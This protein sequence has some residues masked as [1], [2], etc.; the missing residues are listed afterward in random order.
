M[1]GSFTRTGAA[2]GSCLIW[3]PQV[4]GNGKDIS[5]LAFTNQVAPMLLLTLLLLKP[6]A[7]VLCMRSGAPGGLFTP[8]LTAGV[9]LGAVPGTFGL[10]SGPVFP[11]DCSRYLELELFWRQPHKAQS[12]QWF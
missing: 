5:Q 11:L 2:R 9:L 1:G 10:G 3:F 6:A 4:L 12:Q 7:T 8:S